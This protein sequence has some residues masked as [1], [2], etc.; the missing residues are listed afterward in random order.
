[1]EEPTVTMSEVRMDD[2]FRTRMTD[3]VGVY[4]VYVCDICGMPIGQAY[5]E[6]HASWHLQ[7]IRDHSIVNELHEWAKNISQLFSNWIFKGRM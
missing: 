2:V 5:R 4:W 6:K 1:M 3:T 7:L